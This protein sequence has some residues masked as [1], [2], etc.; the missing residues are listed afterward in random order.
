MDNN[1]R[2]TKELKLLRLH[3]N[4]VTEEEI[5]MGKIAMMQGLSL[6]RDAHLGPRKPEAKQT[7]NDAEGPGSS[8]Q[9]GD[10]VVPWEATR[11]LPDV[12]RP[13]VNVPQRREV[14]SGSADAAASGN[15]QRITSPFGAKQRR[16]RRS[17]ERRASRSPSPRSIGPLDETLVGARRP[18]AADRRKR[19]N[20]VGEP[21]GCGPAV[22]EAWDWSL[23][24]APANPP[25]ENQ[26]TLINLDTK[27]IVAASSEA[28]SSQA[29]GQPREAKNFSV[30]VDTTPLEE[31]SDPRSM[32]LG[33]FFTDEKLLEF[34]HV[35]TRWI[36]IVGAGRQELSGA[37]PAN[38]AITV[39]RHENA[40]QALWRAVQL[41][42][43]DE[44]VT[45]VKRVFEQNPFLKWA[46]G[47]RFTQVS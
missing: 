2:V 27:E 30:F 15:S 11:T 25:L 21:L 22:A 47:L 32:P 40:L 46:F 24:D 43:G 34:V 28:S 10:L 39:T 36:E 13:S 8:A 9:R 38:E 19:S 44:R 14:A 33:R 17:A 29:R 20:D 23:L 6:I 12:A 45:E 16:S 35:T 5:E 41:R 7:A 18:V 3:P 1:I 37:A 26:R 42:S 4:D 31:L